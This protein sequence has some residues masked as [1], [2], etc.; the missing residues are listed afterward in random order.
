MIDAQVRVGCESFGK[1]NYTE[2]EN[3]SLRLVAVERELDLG[4]SGK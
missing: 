3:W 1:L 2:I 4:Q